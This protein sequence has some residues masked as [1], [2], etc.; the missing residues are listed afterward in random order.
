MPLTQAKFELT[1]TLKEIVEIEK[2][3]VKFKKGVDLICEM[4]NSIP[5]S[6]RA[7]TDPYINNLFLK[8]IAEK[9][10][11]AGETELADYVL[12]QISQK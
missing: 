1:S 3:P 9:K 6:Q 2:N 11:A 10:K 5:A 8:K 7:Q 4:R 12:K